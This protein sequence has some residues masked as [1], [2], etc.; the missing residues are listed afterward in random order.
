MTAYRPSRPTDYSRLI[1]LQQSLVSPS[2]QLLQTVVATQTIGNCLVS[3]T[4]TQTVVGYALWFTSTEQVA[5]EISTLSNE[6]KDH[7]DED[8]VEAAG[9]AY[10]VDATGSAHLAELAIHP[11]YRRQGRGSQLLTAIFNQL[12]PG[13]QLTLNV[14][15][16]NKPA[17]AL[18]ETAG[19]TPI[20]R[21][22][23]FYQNEINGQTS[24]SDAIMY[25]KVI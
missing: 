10:M 21:H 18:Y 14:A 9:S 24:A 16:N 1:T 5:E 3:I 11:A 17:R 15:I 2:P 8:S 20:C 4:E 13:T 6:S 12:T 7:C 22:E 23:K 25:A 19:F